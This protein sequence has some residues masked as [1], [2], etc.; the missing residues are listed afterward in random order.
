MKI[1][2]VLALLLLASCSSELKYEMNNHK[3]LS[4]ETKGEFLKGDV[5]LSYQHTQNVLLA[6]AYDFVIFNLPASVSTDSSLSR[7]G[8][9]SLPINLGLLTRLD[10]YTLDSKYGFKYQFYGSPEKDRVLE[11]KAAFAAA[12]DSEH[13][14]AGNIIYTNNATTRNY[15]TDIKIKSYELSLILGKR[16]SETLL[17]YVNFMRDYYNYKGALS[18][19]QFSTVNVSGHSTNQGALLGL[20]Y[21]ESNSNHP[22]TA[23]VEAGVVD[24]KLDG[25][26]SRTA[27][28]YGFEAGWSW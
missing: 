25:R 21:L 22:L 5:S 14:E 4:P 18:S 16:V 17:W 19:N 28:T 11:Y 23:K 2:S 1:L 13:N 15:S 9:L 10:F 8:N 27:G 20:H 6:G 7:T 26:N 3:F 24:G 12:Y